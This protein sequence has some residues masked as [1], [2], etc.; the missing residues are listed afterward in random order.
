MFS[1][2]EEK[3]T[4]KDQATRIIVLIAFVMFI[5]LFSI[6]VHI[7][8]PSWILTFI[9]ITFLFYCLCYSAGIMM[10][11]PGYFSYYQGTV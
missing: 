7:F 5:T 10:M 2:F 4:P 3:K 11:F 9:V 8:I 1:E 6:I